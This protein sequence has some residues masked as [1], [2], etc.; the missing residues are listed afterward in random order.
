MNCSTSGVL[1]ST[2]SVIGALASQVA[3][4]FLGKRINPIANELLIWQGEQFQLK[5]LNICRDEHC[6][7]CGL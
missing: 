4:S 1:A 5:K 7:V 3:L 2:V 6:S